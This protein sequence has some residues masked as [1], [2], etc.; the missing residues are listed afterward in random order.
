MR[1]IDISPII[2]STLTFC[3]KYR[4][5]IYSHT[6]QFH[7]EKTNT[8]YLF[9]MASYMKKVAEGPLGTG[10]AFICLSLL[11]LL[12]LSSGRKSIIPHISRS[13]WSKLVKLMVNLYCLWMDAEKMESYGCI[14][15]K[16]GKWLNDTCFIPG[17]CN[18]PCRDEGFDSGHCKNLWTCICYKNCTGLSL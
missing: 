18:A 10:K 1:H 16:S 7:L 15:R 6:H 14:K 8:H 11:M 13:D 4:S 2:V 9:D 17:T 12:V 5:W 3:Y